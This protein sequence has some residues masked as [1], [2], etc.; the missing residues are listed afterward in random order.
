[1]S[2]MSRFPENFNVHNSEIQQEIMYTIY[3]RNVWICKKKLNIQNCENSTANCIN[4]M[5]GISGFAENLNIQNCTNST[6]NCV[7]FMCGMSSFA[8]N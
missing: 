7:H 2:G 6:G 3:V 4:C 8:E 5:C 1:M